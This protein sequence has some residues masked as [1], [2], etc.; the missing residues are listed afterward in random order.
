M[1]DLKRDQIGQLL[2]LVIALPLAE[3]G[4]F[5]GTSEERDKVAEFAPNPAHLAT[6]G[7]NFADFYRKRLAVVFSSGPRK[8]TRALT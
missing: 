2:R 4:Y 6:L 7:K 5:L 8:R 3:I 1:F